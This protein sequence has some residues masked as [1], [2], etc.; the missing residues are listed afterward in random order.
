MEK[1]EFPAFAPLKKGES[2]AAALERHARALADRLGLAAGMSALCLASRE[3]AQVISRYSG[4]RVF[5][6]NSAA[7]SSLDAV[8]VLGYPLG[9]GPVELSLSDWFRQLKPGGRLGLVSWCLLERF[10]SKDP[11]H[12]DIKMQLEDFCGGS[13]YTARTVTNAVKLRG[14]QLQ[15]EKDLAVECD[16][17]APWHSVLQGPEILSLIKAGRFGLATPLYF[18]QAVKP[19]VTAGA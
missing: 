12:Q 18:V 13:L 17:D 6:E 1:G 4:A 3:A 15:F 7:E 5:V 14:F 9:P 11:T 10:D 2:H 16:A 8:A 19:M